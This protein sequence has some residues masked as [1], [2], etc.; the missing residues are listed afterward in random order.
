M[1]CKN[2]WLL[3][4]IIKRNSRKLL[5]GGEPT[6]PEKA[7]VVVE[8]LAELG[9]DRCNNLSDGPMEPI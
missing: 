4:E 7:E 5:W 1:N 9:V 3:F 8:T 6:L 2:P